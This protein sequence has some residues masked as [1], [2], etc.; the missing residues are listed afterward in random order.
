VI[1]KIELNQ[2]KEIT[3]FRL[4]EAKHVRA[5][6]KSGVLNADDRE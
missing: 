1:E 2:E 6:V 3:S 5:Q 4:R